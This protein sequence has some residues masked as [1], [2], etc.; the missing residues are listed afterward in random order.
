VY[1]LVAIVRKRLK[2]DASLHSILQI[3][4]VMPFEKMPFQQAFQKTGEEESHPIPLNQLILF[5][6]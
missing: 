6:F 4:S 2:L 1:L 5:D 3:C